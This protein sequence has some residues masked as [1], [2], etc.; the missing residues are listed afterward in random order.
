MLI[1]KEEE[2]KKEDEGMELME[3]EEVIDGLFVGKGKYG[4]VFVLCVCNLF[5]LLFVEF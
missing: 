1:L 3:D 2:G 4:Y 5:M